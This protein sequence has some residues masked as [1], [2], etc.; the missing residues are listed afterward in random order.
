[1]QIN[2]QELIDQLLS[3]HQE[4]KDTVLK[5]QHLPLE[6]LNWKSS[7]TEWSI[8]ECLEHLNLYGD[9]YHPE[10]EGKLAKGKTVGEDHIFKS[11]IL[12]NHFVK[13]IKV[14][15]GKKFKALSYMTPEVSKLSTETIDHFLIHMDHLEKLLIR[16]RNLNI[17]KLKTSVTF[18]RL[19]KMKLGDTL[20]FMVYHNERHIR[21]AEWVLK[22]VGHFELVN[23][24]E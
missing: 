3:L 1:M 15:S 9:Y 23:L 21:Q 2:Q 4:L 8:L 18:S 11:G 24:E 19:L 5:L 10:I 7:A 14:D 20:R 17:A 6:T 22:K 12:G 13:I 16:A